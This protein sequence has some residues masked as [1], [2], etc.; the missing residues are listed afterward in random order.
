MRATK[1]SSH[2]VIFL[3]VFFLF[4]VSCV[5]LYLH[6]RKKK[7]ARLDNFFLHAFT[8]QKKYDLTFF[9]THVYC[10]KRLHDH[11]AKEKITNFAENACMCPPVG[12]C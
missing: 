4:A 3:F 7:I 10:K 8:A 9:F 11:T 1:K 12:H 2:R 5:N 6:Y